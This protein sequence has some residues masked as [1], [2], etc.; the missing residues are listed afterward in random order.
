MTFSH[1]YFG[2]STSIQ[3]TRPK[4]LKIIS[5][6]SWTASHVNRSVNFCTYHMVNWAATISCFG[7]IPIFSVFSRSAPCFGLDSSISFLIPYDPFENK[8]ESLFSLGFI[9]K[10]S[11]WIQPSFNSKKKSRNSSLFFKKKNWLY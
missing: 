5:S 7:C 10:P 2:S 9:W 4:V 3:H 6:T 8:R 11:I 1:N